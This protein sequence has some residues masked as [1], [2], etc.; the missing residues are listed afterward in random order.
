LEHGAEERRA[1]TTAPRTRFALW[2]ETPRR[3]GS[4]ASTVGLLF[5]LGA[6]LL[7]GASLASAEPPKRA[8]PEYALK[9]TFLIRLGAFVTWPAGRSPAPARELAICVLGRDPFGDYL[10][11]AISAS[12]PERPIRVSRI[13]DVGDARECHLLFLG[14]RKA[15]RYAELRDQLCESSVLTVSDDANFVQQGGMIGFIRVGDRVELHIN[16]SEVERVG[17][18]VSSELLQIARIGGPVQ[19]CPVAEGSAD[20]SA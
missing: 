17:L 11:A 5:G 8:V 3:I 19:A 7:W 12:P 16:R 14:E 2:E 6:S 18:R 20:D 4:V 1:V 13:D 10:D 15:R 9:A